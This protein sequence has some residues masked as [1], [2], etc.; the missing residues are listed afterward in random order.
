MLCAY[1]NLSIKFVVNYLIIFLVTD[2]QN[3]PSKVGENQQKG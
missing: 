2:E 1:V 3:K